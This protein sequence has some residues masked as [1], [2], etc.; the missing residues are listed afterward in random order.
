MDLVQFRML[1]HNFFHKDADIV[2]EKTHLIIL[3]SKSSVCMA[4]NGED[5]KHT[6]H[7]SRRVHFV[8]NG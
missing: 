6:R 5:T 4:D 1:I 3:D 7:I 8:R 2:S